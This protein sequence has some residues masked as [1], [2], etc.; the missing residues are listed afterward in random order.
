[1]TRKDYIKIAAA[2]SRIPWCDQKQELI[3]ELATVLQADNPQ[4]SQAKFV[5][6]CCRSL[7]RNWIK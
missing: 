4:F 1:M 6:A 5:A 2:V 7:D 3:R